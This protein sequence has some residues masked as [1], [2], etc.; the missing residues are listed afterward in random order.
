[1]TTSSIRRRSVHTAHPRRWVAAPTPAGLFAVLGGCLL[2]GVSLV[3]LPWAQVCAV[4]AVSVVLI[5]VILHP[6]VAAYLLLTITPLVAGIDRGAGI[7][8]LRPTEA[9]A[10]LVGAGLLTR[11]VLVALHEGVPPLRPSTTDIAIVA[12]LATG[13]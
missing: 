2:L 4:I 11:G 1:M 13:S 6:Q 10:A 8:F 7:P 12:L 3:V 9:L 5:V